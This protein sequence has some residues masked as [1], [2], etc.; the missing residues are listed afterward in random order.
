MH[1]CSQSPS[2]PTPLHIL[3]DREGLVEGK[4]IW[5]EIDEKEKGKNSSERIVWWEEEHCVQRQRSYCSR[6]FGETDEENFRIF[7][8]VCMMY[9]YKALKPPFKKTYKKY[10]HYSLR[11]LELSASL[12]PFFVIIG[13]KGCISRRGWLRDGRAVF[14]LHQAVG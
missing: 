4:R 2:P 11:C 8:F 3:N 5:G 14:R 6:D 10:W 7:G 1:A 12:I 13:G 9:S